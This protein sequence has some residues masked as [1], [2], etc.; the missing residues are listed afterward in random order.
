MVIRPLRRERLDYLFYANPAFRLLPCPQVFARQLNHDSR[1]FLVHICAEMSQVARQQM[2][3]AS[4]DCCE[5]YG[6]VLVWEGDAD[7]Q[8]IQSHFKKLETIDELRQ[9]P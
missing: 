1:D 4:I 2:S 6:R 7:G 3:S 8:S 5:K 9:S